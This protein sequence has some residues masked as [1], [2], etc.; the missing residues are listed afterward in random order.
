MKIA[1]TLLPFIFFLLDTLPAQNFTLVDSGDLFDDSGA[2]GC[3]WGDFDNNGFL[4]LFAS[5]GQLYYNNGDGTFTEIL[6]GDVIDNGN[7]VGGTTGD[8]DND[9]FLDLY[10]GSTGGNGGKLFHNNGDGT[11]AQVLEEPFLSDTSDYQASSWVD[12]D[13]DGDLDLFVCAGGNVG[14]TDNYLY[15]NNNDGTF[16]RDTTKL[17]TQDSTGSVNCSWSD[18]NNDGYVDLFIANGA[19]GIDS[20]TNLLYTNNGDGSFSRIFTGALTN[21][22]D[23]SLG[24]SWG[25]Y[26]NDGFLDLFVANVQTNKLY[27]NNGDNTFSSINAGELVTENFLS[28]G[29]GWEDFDNDGD[30]DLMVANLN[31]GNSFFE[32]NGNGTFSKIQG[33]PFS[34]H[35]AI[36]CAWADWDKDGDQDIIFTRTGFNKIT[37]YLNNGNGNNWIN[38]K[39]T[40]IVSNR[41]GIGT[42]IWLKAII[43]GNPVCQVREISGQT[44]VLGQSSL[45]AHFGLGSGGTIDSIRVEWPSG[46]VQHITDAVVNNHLEIVE[47]ISLNVQD[48][49]ASILNEFAV[50]PNPANALV[51]IEFELSQSANISVDIMDIKGTIVARLKQVEKTAG[52]HQLTFQSHQIPSGI[53]NCLISIDNKLAGSQQIVVQR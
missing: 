27:K 38:I 49:E 46:I 42:K 15:V 13:H 14:Y 9:G 5:D 36:G 45:N 31:T 6:S 3:A 23:I 22:Q 20:F 40:G 53:Y 8:Y 1:I 25:D 17:I 30:L 18:F 26:N 2:L 4:D 34:D 44:G 52:L 37:P 21:D 16:T 11:F 10:T 33:E 28:A 43:D 47:E 24:S 35:E 51:N 32:N 48:A 41:S 19:I 7:G 12:F 39:C 50:F 29:S